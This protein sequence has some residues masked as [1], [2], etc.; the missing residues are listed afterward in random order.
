MKWCWRSRL[1][2]DRL[3]TFNDVTAD[4]PRRRREPLL[5]SALGKFHR[6][7]VGSHGASARRRG[8]HACQSTAHDWANLEPPPFGGRSIRSLLVHRHPPASPKA[9]YSRDVEG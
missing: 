1:K 7:G 2:A 9:Q 5:A 8:R 3:L 6:A 4:A